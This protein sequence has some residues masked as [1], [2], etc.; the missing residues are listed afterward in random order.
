M[1]ERILRMATEADNG[2]GNLYYHVIPSIIKARGY[3]SCLEV[4]VA[5]A[6]HAEAMIKAGIENYVGVDAYKVYPGGFSDNGYC[7]TQEDYD[8][9]YRFSCKRLEQTGVQASLFRMDSG[10]L[11]FEDHSFD[12]VFIDADHEYEPV[13]LELDKCYPLVK[14]GGLLSGH[15]YNHSGFPGVTKA[16]DEFCAAKGLKL[17]LHDGYVWSVNI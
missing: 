12:V 2:W 10:L 16:V 5:W 15:D 9:L 3:K 4:G 14:P 11:G 6:G 8:N 17:N 13:K 7:F 1:T